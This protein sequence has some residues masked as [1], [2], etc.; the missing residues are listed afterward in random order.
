MHSF[1]NLLLVDPKMISLM[2]TWAINMS[3]LYV[4]INKVG[5][6][7]T[8]LNPFELKY[9]DSISYQAL[10][11]CFNPYNAFFKFKYLIWTI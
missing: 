3:L 1:R 2:Y 8:Y 6:I 10:G 11:V 5:S 4:F 9:I 7:F